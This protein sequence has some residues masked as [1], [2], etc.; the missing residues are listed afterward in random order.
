MKLILGQ[1]PP[2]NRT[3]VGLDS[4]SEISAAISKIQIEV[5]VL[6]HTVRIELD[7]APIV[8]KL[9][10]HG[11][12]VSIEQELIAGHDTILRIEDHQ[13][14][15]V[16]LH[17][18]RGVI[19][20]R[21]G[22]VHLELHYTVIV[23]VLQ[24]EVVTNNETTR[25]QFCIDTPC[26]S[27][28]DIVTLIIFETCFRIGVKSTDTQFSS[29]PTIVSHGNHVVHD[30]QLILTVTAHLDTRTIDHNTLIACANNGVYCRIQG[31]LHKLRNLSSLIRSSIVEVFAGIKTAA[32]RTDLIDLTQP[33]R[34]YVTFLE[35]V[36]KGQCQLL[37]VLKV[38]SYPDQLR[39]DHT[40]ITNVQINALAELQFILKRLKFFLEQEISCING[41]LVNRPCPFIQ[42]LFAKCVQLLRHRIFLILVHIYCEKQLGCARLKRNLGA[43]V[44]RYPILRNRRNIT[45]EL[46]KYAGCSN[47]S[48]REAMLIKRRRSHVHRQ[49]IFVCTWVN[50]QSTT[51][52]VCRQ[53][54]AGNFQNAA[55]NSIHTFTVK[56]CLCNISP[57][58]CNLPLQCG[59][60]TRS[61]CIYIGRNESFF[62]RFALNQIVVE[63]FLFG[64]CEIL[65]NR[66]LL[67]NTLN[68]S[69]I[70]INLCLQ[71]RNH[72]FLR[73]NLRVLCRDFLI[74]LCQLLLLTCLSS[75]S[76]F[77]SHC[78]DNYALLRS[79]DFQIAFQ[80]SECH[81]LRQ[82]LGGSGCPCCYQIGVV[83]LVAFNC[84]IPALDAL[85]QSNCAAL[86]DHIKIAVGNEV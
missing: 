80:R 22:G 43:F 62:C 40:T 74:D 66:Q 30:T 84:S 73:L 31:V 9:R 59:D 25:K 23:G 35:T 11:C 77:Q 16:M 32:G 67:Y 1:F 55:R 79:Q 51:H 3:G 75:G 2:A 17:N 48:A 33:I 49:Y 86:G 6:R 36:R 69:G 54:C 19:Q 10:G 20:P 12:T 45:A 29:L 34:N 76:G 46:R 58:Q 68:I 38:Q 47:K 41:K 60:G 56:T 18:V 64:F 82:P 52:N 4:S 70:P 53:L 21:S 50:L 85:G 5:C 13:A 78:L 44:L 71:I 7:I 26:L 39:L 37:G 65:G 61:R 27:N 15:V 81:F 63:D 72:C 42:K 24:D 57:G 28:Q 83:S 8:N 14:T